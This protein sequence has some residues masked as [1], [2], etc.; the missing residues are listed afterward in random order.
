[1]ASA[2]SGD[3]GKPG[4][5]LAETSHPARLTL[6]CSLLESCLLGPPNSRGALIAAQL[7]WNGYV[8][9]GL[10]APLQHDYLPIPIRTGH[11]NAVPLK[12]KWFLNLMKGRS[13]SLWAVANSQFALPPGFAIEVALVPPVGKSSLERSDTSRTP[14][15]SYDG[16]VR[17]RVLAFTCQRTPDR[18]RMAL[19]SGCVSTAVGPGLQRPRSSTEPCTPHSRSVSHKARRQRFRRFA[20]V[21]KHALFGSVDDLPF[22]VW[23]TFLHET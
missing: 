19:C 17:L 8:V 12:R 9:S 2:Q 13:R 4:S 11:P 15:N 20:L 23:F 22:D 16:V 1:M 6:I 14:F 5:K 18:P 3:Q 7:K 10:L 21:S